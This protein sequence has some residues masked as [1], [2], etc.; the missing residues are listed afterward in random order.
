MRMCTKPLNTSSVENEN[1]PVFDTVVL[2]AAADEE[3]ERHQK[4]LRYMESLKE[5][6]VYIAGFALL[7][8]DVVLKSRNYSFDERMAMHGL[9]LRDFPSV[10]VKVLPL[11]PSIFYLTARLEKELGLD[12]FDAG[13]AA[14]AL[15]HDGAVVSTDRAFDKVSHLRRLW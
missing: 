12:Y 15:N 10:R 3:D 11:S 6:G 7:E 13:V 4:A 14:E 2:F 8:F 9:L 1:M 5:R